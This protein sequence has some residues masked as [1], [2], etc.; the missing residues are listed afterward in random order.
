LAIET[1]RFETWRFEIWRTV[2]ERQSGLTSIEI[3]DR[4]QTPPGMYGANLESLQ[5]TAFPFA[6]S[7]CNQY[8]F[9]CITEG[10]LP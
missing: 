8:R 5:N 4:F 1:W 10:F 3:L 2:R 7:A 9:V 6:T